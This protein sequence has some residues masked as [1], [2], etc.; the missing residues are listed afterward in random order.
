[1]NSQRDK[2]FTLVEVSIVLVSVGLLLGGVLKGQEMI[3]NSKLKRVV[4]DNAGLIAAKFSY[5]DR[6][7]QLPGDDNRASDRFDDY[8]VGAPVDG[9]GNGAIDGDWDVPSTG[10]VTLALTAET[11]LFFAHLRASG[12]L[13]GNASDDTR[14]TNA[15]GGQIGIRN[16]A[17]GVAG[18]VLIFG[19]IEGKIGKIIETKLDDGNPATGRIQSGVSSG[20]TPVDMNND[21]T[22]SPVYNSSE[23]YNI[24]F[25]L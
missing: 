18:H 1:M 7:G 25:K 21:P 5:Q 17:L 24:A 3:T 20:A 14:P 23:R 11:N 4:A 9:D 6:Y 10:D 13:T 22:G 12:L 16:G 19:E 8:P 15:F 2:G